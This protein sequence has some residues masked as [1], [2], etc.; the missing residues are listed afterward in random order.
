MKRKWIFIVLLT[1]IIIVGCSKKEV[2]V[3]KYTFKAENKNWQVELLSYQKVIF[4]EKGDK[5]DAETV[6][7]SSLTITYK[8]KLSELYSV[9]HMEISYETDL[10]AGNLVSNFDDGISSKTFTF[11]SVGPITDEY[12]E[13]KVTINLDGEIEILEL[14]SEK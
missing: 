2:H 13:I 4:T 11:N 9:K 14:E 7:N 12:D 1:S 10:S 5:T 8:R 6:S 3:N